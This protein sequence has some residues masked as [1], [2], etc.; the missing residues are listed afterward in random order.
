MTQDFTPE[1]DASLGLVFRLNYLWAQADQAALDGKYD[2][3]NNVLDRIYCNLLY[4]VPMNI[5]R[6]KNGEVKKVELP[7]ADT[8]VYSALSR[9]IQLAKINF[10]G[11]K[12]PMK[13][14]MAR[15][16]W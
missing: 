14:S 9:Q 4:D 2:S 15:S 8:Q 12:N 3:W 5:E 7:P 1:R 10:M 11:A 6:A 16:I 13:K